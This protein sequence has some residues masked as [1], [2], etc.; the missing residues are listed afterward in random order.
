MALN[1]I[2]YEYVMVMIT[3]MK[4]MPSLLLELYSRLFD[5]CIS[6]CITMLGIGL[7]AYIDEL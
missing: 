7:G 5:Y 1:A 4:S 6:M 2:M 3:N